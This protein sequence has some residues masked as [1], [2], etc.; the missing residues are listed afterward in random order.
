[1]TQYG[2]SGVVPLCPEVSEIVKASRKA[3]LLRNDFEW[4]EET[5]LPYGFSQG[6]T[7]GSFPL[8]S[9]RAKIKWEVGSAPV[10]PHNMVYGA[11]DASRTIISRYV[12]QIS[13]L[14]SSGIPSWNRERHQNRSFSRATNKSADAHSLTYM[15][16]SANIRHRIGS[17]IFFLKVSRGAMYV[18]NCQRWPHPM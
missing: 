12:C 3:G 18:Q 1:M 14:V 6:Q 9:V 10:P 15:R 16:I 17:I 8:G 4:F 2:Q 13:Q 7:A 11:F 5:L